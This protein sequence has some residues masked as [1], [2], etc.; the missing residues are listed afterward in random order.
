MMQNAAPQSS[1]LMFWISALRQGLTQREC[2]YTADTI[3]QAPQAGVWDL[4]KRRDVTF[5]ASGVRIVTT[6][7]DGDETHLSTAIVVNGETTPTA[8]V[9]ILEERA[10]EFML[11]ALE[12]GPYSSGDDAIAYTVAALT[13][14]TTR[15]TISRSLVHKSIGSRLMAPFGITSSLSMYRSQVESEAGAAPAATALSTQAFW[16]AAAFASFAW[17]SGW[18]S[19]LALMLVLAIHEGGHVL[20][21]LWYGLGIRTVGFVP[22]FGAF[23]SAKRQPATEWQGCMIALAGVAFSLPFTIAATWWAQQTQSVGIADA[24]TTFFALNLFNLLPFPMLDGGVVTARL[25]NKVSPLISRIVMWGM[26]A[27]LAALAFWLN[28]ITI[29]I[30]A[31]MMLL[32][33]ALA[34]WYKIADEP[35]ETPMRTNAS[36]LMTLLFLGLVAAYVVV[37]AK[38]LQVQTATAAAAAKS[39]AAPKPTQRPMP[40]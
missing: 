25:L 20:A 15:L 1:R 35:T 39:G 8:V 19:A 3:V 33:L 36:V 29:G 37:G 21:M 28:E 31:G 13:P 6:A 34:A 5:A 10:P 26:A 17:L 16:V 2:R 30:L 22:F 12:T 11:M 40:Q 24:A 7:V 14:E 27:L 4:L 9:R 23:V 38:A 32:Q 18:Q